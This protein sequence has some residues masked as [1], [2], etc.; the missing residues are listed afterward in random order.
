MA[1]LKQRDSVVMGSGQTIEEALD[2]WEINLQDHLRHAGSSDPIVQYVAGLLAET[3]VSN[4]V[5]I[6]DDDIEEH[7]ATIKDPLVAAEVKRF[8]DQFKR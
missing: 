6:K 2:A 4:E 3:A 5:E 8:Y 1:E 7:L